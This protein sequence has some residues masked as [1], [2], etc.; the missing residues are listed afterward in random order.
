MVILYYYINIMNQH[1]PQFPSSRA[2][3]FKADADK[4]AAATAATAAG[5]AAAAAADAAAAAAAAAGAADI[6]EYPYKRPKLS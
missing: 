2:A 1:C 6:V 4:A 3:S 5:A